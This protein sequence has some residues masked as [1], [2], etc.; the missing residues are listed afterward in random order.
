[1]AMNE[2]LIDSYLQALKDRFEPWEIVEL[3]GLSNNQII[4]RFYEELIEGPNLLE[5]DR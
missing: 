5:V 1:M 2:G 4:D 3:L